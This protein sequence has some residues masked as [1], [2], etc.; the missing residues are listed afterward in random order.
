MDSL[1]PWRGGSDFHSMLLEPTGELKDPRVSNYTCTRHCVYPHID[2]YGKHTKSTETVVSSKTEI[3]NSFENRKQNLMY[4][5]SLDPNF[6]AFLTHDAT[7]A[8]KTKTNPNRDFTVDHGPIP[9][10]QR[11]TAQQKSAT[12]NLMLGQIA[13]YCPAISRN[14]IVKNSTSLE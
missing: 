6:A 1:Q 14:A 4:S 7:W 10:N 13:N 12:L 9:E 2:K 5:L 3:V 11:H 8:K